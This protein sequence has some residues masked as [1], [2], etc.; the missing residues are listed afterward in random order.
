[1]RIAR[2]SAIVAVV[3]LLNILSGCGGGGVSVNVNVPNLDPAE[4]YDSQ[5][6]E[7]W[8]NLRRGKASL[9]LENFQQS[10][11]NDVNL[12][13]GFGYAFLVQN[14]FSL[15]AQNF[16]KA[17]DLD[18][19]SLQAQLGFATLYEA[20]NE[21]RKAFN[22][23]SRLRVQFPDNPWVK[24][25][26]DYIK[27]TETEKSLRKARQY[28]DQGRDEDYVAALKNAAVFSPETIDIKVQ[29]A[30]FYHQNADYDQA[31]TY[32]E[33][34]LETYP[35]KEDILYKLAG[36]YEQMEKY[37]A[38][39]VIYKKILDLKP[40]DIDISNRIN[41]LKV[42]F[43]DMDLP[44]KFKNIF[45][46]NV[47]NREDL[48]ALIGHYFDKFL[49]IRGVPKII[50]DI[51][52]SYARDYIIKVC[53]LG[54]M[55]LRPDHSFGIGDRS[56]F[57][58]NRARFAVVMHSLIKFLEREGYMLKFTPLEEVLEPADISPLHKNYNIIKFMVNA[59]VLKLDESRNFNPTYDISPSEAVMALKKILRSVE[60]TE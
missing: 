41:D 36:V 20:K 40:G 54:I 56:G 19:E 45:F 18:S 60:I 24:V 12:Y 16:Q 6:L 46:K 30:D 51:A 44:E 48:A 11:A 29:I 17:L 31:V 35:N 13:V 26:Y 49:E 23:Y 15:A 28:Q 9:A 4:S 25:R 7:G 53:T 2:L 57:D 8:E 42:K 38:A 14:K 21:I 1:M 58:V 5:Y 34:I 10:S 39:I 27:S 43:Y 47:I 50:T 32:Y 59:Q 37:D 52:N 33:E 3:V 55:N 22:L